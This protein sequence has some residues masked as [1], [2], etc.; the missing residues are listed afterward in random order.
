MVIPGNFSR[1]EARMLC[2]ERPWWAPDAPLAVIFAV[3]I[4]MDKLPCRLL[5]VSAPGDVTDF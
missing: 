5:L 3:S 2:E 4:D 1:D